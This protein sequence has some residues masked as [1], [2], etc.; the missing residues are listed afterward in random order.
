PTVSSRKPVRQWPCEI[1]ID[2]QPADVHKIVSD[3][4]NWLRETETPKLLFHAEPG[5]IIKASDAKWIQENFPN[6]TVV[7]IGKGL[8]YI[9]EDNPHMIGAELKKWYSKL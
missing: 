2:G 4:H 5:A 3:Y 9:Q 7:N 1:P 6:T 8:H